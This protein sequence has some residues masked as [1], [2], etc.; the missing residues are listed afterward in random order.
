M[1]TKKIT[2]KAASVLAAATMV[3]TCMAPAASAATYRNNNGNKPTIHVEM[4]PDL[5]SSPDYFNFD[6]QS[7]TVNGRT[8]RNTQPTTNRN[9]VIKVTV[10]RGLKNVNYSRKYETRIRGT[11]VTLYGNGNTYF[12]AQWVRNGCGY[13]LTTSK[14]VDLGRMMITVNNHMV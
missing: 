6:G 9:T 14:N 13:T 8:V 2:A 4:N 3:I 1:F 7:Y 5:P 11:A 10:Y 12:A